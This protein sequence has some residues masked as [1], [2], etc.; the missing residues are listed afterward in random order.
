MA[1][2]VRECAALGCDV[3]L[4]ADPA[5]GYLERINAKGEPFVGLCQDHFK[6]SRVELKPWAVTLLERASSPEGGE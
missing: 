3:D 4:L 1:E 2:N 5:S 6:R